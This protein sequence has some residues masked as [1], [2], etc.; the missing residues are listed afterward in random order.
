MDEY[1][2]L[3]HTQWVV[4]KVRSN[5]SSS[6]VA[7]RCASCGSRPAIRRRRLW[8]HPAAEAGI[9][10]GSPLSRWMPPFWRVT[11]GLGARRREPMSGNVNGRRSSKSR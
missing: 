8:R 1:E 7:T 3:N 6:G 10:M 4:A 5:S 9:L 2:S 11:I